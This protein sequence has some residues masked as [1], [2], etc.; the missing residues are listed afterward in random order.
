M[1][2]LVLT[3]DEAAERLRVSRWTLYTLI[4]SNQLKTI[5]IGR[6]RLVP[7]DSLAECVDYLKAVA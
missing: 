4:R 6:R 2:D 7:V 5:K 1:D 3:V